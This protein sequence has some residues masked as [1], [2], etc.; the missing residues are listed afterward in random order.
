[1]SE[2]VTRG[3]GRRVS[4][5]ADAI[6][7]PII[8]II[9][10][11]VFAILIPIIIQVLQGVKA[12]EAGITMLQSAVTS[13]GA[14]IPGYTQAYQQ[15]GGWFGPY[16]GLAG[17]SLYGLVSGQQPTGYQ[18]VGQLVYDPTTK[19]YKYQAGGS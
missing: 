4:E 7:D 11:L 14:Q 17:P 15:T 9:T 1:M 5:I 3:F 13:T 19:T 8:G 2:I 12:A 16:G 18:Q 6:I 10:L